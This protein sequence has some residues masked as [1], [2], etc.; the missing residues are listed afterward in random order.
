MPL[1]PLCHPLPPGNHYFVL[2]VHKFVYI[3]HMNEIVWCLSFPVWLISRDSYSTCSTVNPIYSHHFNYHLNT[4]TS[5]ICKPIFPS[6]VPD[7][8]MIL[9]MGYLHLADSQASQTQCRGNPVFP[10]ANLF[11]LTIFQIIYLKVILKSSLHSPSLD[12][13]HQIL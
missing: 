8:Y 2:F 7:P 3:P 10:S 9:L 6:S 1:H 4:N 13:F 5:Q 12:F 11:L